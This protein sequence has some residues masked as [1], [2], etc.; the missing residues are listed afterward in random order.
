[1]NFIQ[2]WQRQRR[3]EKAYRKFWEGLEAAGIADKIVACSVPRLKPTR[4][5]QWQING[6]RFTPRHWPA[7]I[8]S[9]VAGWWS[10]LKIWWFW[11]SSPFNPFRRCPGCAGE[12]WIT[13]SY[14]RRECDICNGL[15]YIKK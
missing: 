6:W 10:R 5:Q 14:T 1:M 15:G 12:K 4:F 2:H 7:H 9:L 11:W 13:N 8:G 3:E